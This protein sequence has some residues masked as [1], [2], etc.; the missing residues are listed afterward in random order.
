MPRAIPQF[1]VG[2]LVGVPCGRAG[3]ECGLTPPSDTPPSSPPC[4]RW[5]VS[6]TFCDEDSIRSLPLVGRAAMLCEVVPAATVAQHTPSDAPRRAGPSRLASRLEQSRAT[7]GRELNT[8]PSAIVLVVRYPP[9]LAAAGAVLEPRGDLNL[10]RFTTGSVVRRLRNAMT[11][12]SMPP[13]A[14]RSRFEACRIREAAGAGWWHRE[15]FDAIGPTHTLLTRTRDAVMSA[16][17]AGADPTAA[18]SAARVGAGGRHV[19]LSLAPPTDCPRVLGGFGAIGETAARLTKAAADAA[20]EVHIPSP[21]M[22]VAISRGAPT[23]A[24]TAAGA[25]AASITHPMLRVSATR[26]HTLLLVGGFPGLRAARVVCVPVWETCDVDGRP[27][28][29]GAEG[30]SGEPSYY[31]PSIRVPS[32]PGIATAQRGVANLTRMV[33]ERDAVGGCAFWM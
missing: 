24:P 6:Y 13:A 31:I 19:R 3:C 15:R 21:Y 25:L 27:A 9:A 14:S 1:V 26:S 4:T 5:Y 7:W 23:D 12:T 28:A 29:G 17:R 11:T 22:D 10:Y 30:G 20:G 18:A 33:D 8:K 32:V 2:S 16:I